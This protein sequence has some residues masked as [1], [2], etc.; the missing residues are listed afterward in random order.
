MLASAK[1]IIIVGR[2]KNNTVYPVESDPA[3]LLLFD[4]SA[5]SADQQIVAEY[6]RKILYDR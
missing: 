1:F 2:R 5:I 3:L 4:V 6:T